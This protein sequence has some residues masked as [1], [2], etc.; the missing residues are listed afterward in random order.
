MANT[1]TVSVYQINGYVIPRDQA[2]RIAFPTTGNLFIDVTASP[3][4]SL[5][6]GYNVYGLIIS[7]V[8]GNWYYTAETAAQ[9]ATL[10]G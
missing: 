1:F 3:T 2:Q 4:R 5:S 9:L 10:A 6:S 8:T 7:G